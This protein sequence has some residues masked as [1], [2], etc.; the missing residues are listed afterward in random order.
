MGL[1]VCICVMV[2]NLNCNK[3]ERYRAPKFQTK[4]NGHA[5]ITSLNCDKTVKF[6]CFTCQTNERYLARPSR[7][8][9]IISTTWGSFD[10][11]LKVWLPAKPTISLCQI[12]GNPSLAKELRF[13]HTKTWKNKWLFIIFYTLGN[14]K[15]LQHCEKHDWPKVKDALGK[16]YT[17]SFLS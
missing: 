13:A 8:L 14:L 10:A 12:A 4:N 9:G 11:Q 16:I 7:G 5:D 15:I 1:Y 6:V 3:C 2:S 17:I